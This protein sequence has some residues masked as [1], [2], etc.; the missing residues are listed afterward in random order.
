MKR[1]L[2]ALLVLLTCSVG[3]QAQYFV[4]GQFGF[5]TTGGSQK[6]G[7]VTVDKPKNT[8]FNF[9]PSIGKFISDKLAVGVSLN[10]TA[11]S[12]KTTVGGNTYTDKTTGFGIAPFARYYFLQMNKFGIFAQG[13]IGFSYSDSKQPS[14]GPDEEIK[15]T[16]FG[17][18]ILPV[19]YYNVSEKLSLEASISLFNFG[20]NTS[21]QKDQNNNKDITNSFGFGAGLDGLVNTG[22]FSIGA[23]YK[24]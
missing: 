8:S 1:I 16:T 15:T 5:N 23:I 21:T 7:G 6:S 24:F 17:F 13:Q 2:F 18:I 14:V 4:G 19:V 3:A 11:Q 10:F 20:F 22:N 12:L 9:S